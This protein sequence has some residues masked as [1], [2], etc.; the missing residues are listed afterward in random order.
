ML[1]HVKSHD[2]NWTVILSDGGTYS[3][4]PS[5]HSYI[6]LVN[7]VNSGN[8]ALFLSSFVTETKVQEWSSTECPEFTITGGVLRFNEE[9][10]SQE[11]TSRVMEMIAGGY[12]PEP[13]MKFLK[14]LYLNVSRRAIVESYKWITKKGIAIN[15]EGML[16]GYK[17]VATY[18]GPDKTDKNK[19]NLRSGDLVDKYTKESYRNNPGDCPSMNRRNVCDDH[20]VGCSTGLHVGT[21]EYAVD[22]AGLSGSVVLVRFDPAD[23][24]SVPSHCEFQKMR[25]SRYKVLKLVRRPIES[26]VYDEDNASNTDDENDS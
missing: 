19:R 8:E 16:I 13:L 10:V 1:P 17:G 21:Y 20:T 15:S 24:V 5:H 14:R 11:I 23:I 2:N 26:L 22:W 3:F 9:T 6:T 18:S 7:A 4:C 12:K 25:V